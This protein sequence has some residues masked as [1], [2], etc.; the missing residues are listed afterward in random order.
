MGF[1]RTSTCVILTTILFI[2]LILLALFSVVQWSSNYDVLKPGLVSYSK[3]A[4]QNGNLLN[5]NLNE[6]YSALQTYC[7][8]HDNYIYTDGNIHLEIPC[9]VVNKGMDS[10]IDYG[11][12]NILQNIYYKNYTCGFMNCL[13]QDKNPLVLVSEKAHLF[14][15]AK[16]YIMLLISIILFILLFLCT[17]KKSNSFIITGILMV[18]V[19]LITKSIDFLLVLVPQQIRD[20]VGL[21]FSKSHTV[22]L[23]FLITGIALIFIGIL[24]KVL[25]LEVK[26]AERFSK[27]DKKGISEDKVRKIVRDEMKSVKKSPKKKSK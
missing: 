12:N 23:I 6:G 14:L 20:I 17:K 24:I 19:S 13:Q 16:F 1:I 25:K 11:V 26:I 7:L 2:S 18:L 22:F 21:F 4:L 15:R 5:F 9:D 10:V 8:M 3:S 27:K